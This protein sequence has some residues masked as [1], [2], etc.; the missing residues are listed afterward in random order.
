MFVNPR[1]IVRLFVGAFASVPLLAGVVVTTVL[2][3]APV[4]LATE[5]PG[6]IQ[7]VVQHCVEQIGT[8]AE[9]T[10]NLLEARAAFAVQRIGNLDANDAPVPV[11]IATAREAQG[12]LD[13]LAGDGTR[14]INRIAFNCVQFLHSVD[15]PQQAIQIVLNARS[16]ALASIEAKTRQSKRAVREALRDAL[17]DEDLPGGD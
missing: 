16:A 2:A 14:R 3:G 17:E 13:E 7:M 5:D 1:S 8:S 15:A 11:M 6:P 4:A 12:D 9:R 10:R